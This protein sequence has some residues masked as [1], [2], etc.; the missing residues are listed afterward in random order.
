MFGAVRVR[1]PETAKLIE[2]LEKQHA[3]RA[4]LI[5]EL[6]TAHKAF[7]AGFPAGLEELR[8][9]VHAYV[10][11]QRE[12]IALEGRELIPAARNHLEPADWGAINRAFGT[13]SDPLFDENMETGSRALSEKITR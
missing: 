3:E 6:D 7:D 13:D 9:V 11:F 1:C 4:R 8:A 5:N 2:R 10:D 12:H